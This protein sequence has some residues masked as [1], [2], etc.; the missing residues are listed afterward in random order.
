MHFN[1]RLSI[2]ESVLQKL[3]HVGVRPLSRANGPYIVPS[4]FSKEYTDSFVNKMK[5]Y[6]SLGELFFFPL[7]SL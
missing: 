2:C 5:I 6:T 1:H 7:H 4:L 3:T